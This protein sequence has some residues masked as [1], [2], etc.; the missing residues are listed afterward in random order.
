M[1]HASGGFSLEI[2]GLRAI[3][4]VAVVLTHLGITWLPGGFVG[5][6][7]FF[8]ISG[9]LI[10]GLLL[11][12]QENGGTVSLA[13]FY[14]RR[15]RRLLPAAALVM[16]SIVACIN[17]LPGVVRESTL[18][19]VIAS[20]V[21]LQNWWLA[22][23]A[24]DYLAADNSPGP[25]QHFWSLSLEEQYYIFWPLL[26]GLMFLLFKG[27]RR[28]ARLV[29]QLLCG[30]VFFVSFAYCIYITR[31]EPGLAYFSTAA[32]AWEL[33]VGGLLASWVGWKDWNPRLRSFIGW[34]GLFSI[35]GSLFLI[36]ATVAFPGWVAMFPVVGA[37]MLICAGGSGGRYGAGMLLRTAP[38]Q[39]L[40]DI[41]YSLYL[42]HWPVIIL[43]KAITGRDLD[44]V[45]MLV[46]AGVSVALAFTSKI[47]IED[48]TRD[49]SWLRTNLRTFL[50]GIAISGT[51]IA[52]AWA[53]RAQ[54]AVRGVA[55]EIE[56]VA[57]VDVNHPGAAALVNGTEQS[58]KYDV[59]A[60]PELV[61]AK[62][63]VPKA[64]ADGCITGQRHATLNTCSY[65]AV[66]AKR[67]VVLAGDSH[68]V[69]WLPALAETGK[70]SNFEVVTYFKSSCPLGDVMVLRRDGQAY[71]ACQEWNRALKQELL[72]NSAELVIFAQSHSYMAA[73]A[74]GR[75][76]SNQMLE[77]GVF[78]LLQ[79]LRAEGRKVIVIRDTPRM[80]RNIPEC[81]ST[82]GVS[83]CGVS[84]S[85]ALGRYEPLLG[86]ARRSEA[87][88][89]DF[90]DKIC[91]PARCEPYVGNVLVWRDSNH[92]TAT[93]VRTMLSSFQNELAKHIE[94]V[95][96]D[97]VPAGAVAS[98][99]AM[100][101]L[102]PRPSEARADNSS[103]YAKGCHVDQRSSDPIPCV[104]GNEHALRKI[105]IV[106]DSHAAQWVPAFEELLAGNEFQLVSHTKSACAFSEQR[107]LLG[108][109]GAVYSSCYEWAQKVI[110]D[111]L[112]N[113]PEIVFV[114]L[115]RVQYAEGATP[116][117]NAELLASG[118]A[119]MLRKL[120]DAGI[121]VVVIGDTP[122]MGV[123]VPECLSRRG[124]S[125]EDCGRPSAPLLA[126]VDPLRVAAANVG[127]EII[128]FD[129]RICPGE[130]CP[131][132]LGNTLVW[133]DAHH[134]TA[135][136][137]RDFA[138]DFR[139]I[140]SE[141]K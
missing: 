84:R 53:L 57:G 97:P 38:M 7:V 28:N 130:T 78:E 86:A 119:K 136:F 35:I 24:V 68:A 25:L 32:R 138:E 120:R 99:T 55:A 115:S 47:L 13:R 93:Y 127:V 64:Y 79:G 50:F 26:L 10:T 107:V 15:V 70:Q 104:Y 48:S 60:I 65:G 14:G 105:A 66:G 125:L 124:A 111:L 29:Y 31:V 132:A 95:A 106:G 46:A 67:K 109:A 44:G 49:A 135:T 80:E 56:V 34:M 3:A 83:A 20:T 63:D 42:W 85:D 76:Q 139:A 27:L 89:M 87:A 61:S 19:E 121:R 51:T 116:E 54:P 8:V 131:A 5:V 40:G 16:L 69:Q 6:D 126:R 4:V 22:G 73:E 41:S 58:R 137:A 141:K 62:D 129:R 74:K 71:D 92:L 98:V 96:S 9:Y 102:R 75:E 114:S 77:A 88:V 100:D 39:F 82:S 128:D 59:A 18:N 122:R 101:S 140:L 45:D 90:S 2:Q 12:E 110:N 113:K 133:R 23:Q 36:N 21:Y 72:K 1:K 108:K 112:S 103:I 94:V 81:V 11:R 117:N 33:A 134:L 123:D 30:V 52:I 91:G 17:Y 37:A 43:F 118:H